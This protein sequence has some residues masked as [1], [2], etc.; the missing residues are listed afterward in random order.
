LKIDITRLEQELVPMI[1]EVADWNCVAEP[2]MLLY[3]GSR[4]Q[5]KITVTADEDEFIEIDDFEPLISF[6]KAKPPTE[7][8]LAKTGVLIH[9][10]GV[11]G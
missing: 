7:R 1:K 3:E 11:L 6:S 5:I 10:P 8:P 9:K 2:S 4:Y